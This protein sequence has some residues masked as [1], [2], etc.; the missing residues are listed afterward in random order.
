MDSLFLLTFDISN[1][2][3]VFLGLRTTKVHVNKLKLNFSDPVTGLQHILIKD[4]GNNS[5]PHNSPSSQ[6]VDQDMG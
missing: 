4:E 2:L 5:V 3:N 1:F 6:A